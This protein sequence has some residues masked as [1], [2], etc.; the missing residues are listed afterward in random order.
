M[1]K[2]LFIVLLILGLT[3]RSQQSDTLQQGKASY[4]ASKFDGRKTS[5]GEIFRNDSLTAA[6]KTL[7]FGTMVKVTSVKAGTSV[8]VRVNDRLP[9]TSKR[10]ID[11]SQNAASQLGMLKKGLDFVIVEVIKD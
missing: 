11:L 5:S 2:V 4:Y 7:P 10:I 6:H 9:K 1:R 3:V 8:I